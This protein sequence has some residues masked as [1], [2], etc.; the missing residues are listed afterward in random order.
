MSNIFRKRYLTDLILA[1]KKNI[2][3]FDDFFYVEIEFRNSLII[4]TTNTAS[5]LFI[6]NKKIETTKFF[7]MLMLNYKTKIVDNL[8]D[9]LLI[10]TKMKKIYFIGDQ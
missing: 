1:F 8:L 4:L 3:I 6:L 5:F 10:R 2:T 9:N 7:S